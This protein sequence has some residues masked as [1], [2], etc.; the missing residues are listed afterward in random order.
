MLVTWQAIVCPPKKLQ[1]SKGLI[2]ENVDHLAGN[3]FPPKKLQ[4]SK[5][6]IQENF[7]HLTGNY[8]KK[9]GENGLK[10]AEAG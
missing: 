8:G 10:P 1:K 9:Q 4:K 5:G 2:Q 3:S 7:V 6:L